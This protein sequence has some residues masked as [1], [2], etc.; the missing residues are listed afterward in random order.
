MTVRTSG[1]KSR[2]R[3][4]S[5]DVG[6]PVAGPE[7][8]RAKVV[9]V[10]DA[11]VGKTSLVR[12][13]VYGTF[14]EEYVATLGVVLSKRAV[15]VVLD[16]H[17]V[18]VAMVLWDTMG[19]RIL[20]DSLG[21]AYLRDAKGVLIVCDGS[22][23]ATVHPVRA[24]ITAARRTAASAALAVL[25]NKSDLGG[26]PRADIEALGA[27]T[28]F[29]APCYR[30]S[31]RTGENV[32][33]A[34]EALAC[35]IAAR[36]ILPEDGPLDPVSM[37]LVIDASVRPRALPELVASARRPEDTV[38]ARAEALVRRGYLRMT[39]MGLGP[40]GRPCPTFTATG[41]AFPRMGAG[42]QANRARDAF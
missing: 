7:E 41:K 29:G 4:G 18:R 13:Y 31:A 12:R 36:A 11:R 21:E 25:L 37:G 1:A 34:L 27:A 20:A 6:P 16:E 23:A 19:E 14:A 8:L 22:D 5:P 40:E 30:T 15:D 24:W 38:L 10:G 2:N 33:A 35:R 39:S 17:A 42:A 9:L 3:G 26:D 32:R 28:E